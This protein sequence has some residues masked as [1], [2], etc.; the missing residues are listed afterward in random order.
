MTHILSFSRLV[1]LA[2]LSSGNRYLCLR[3]HECCDPFPWLPQ[4]ARLPPSVNF[5]KFLVDCFACKEFRCLL[6]FV[7]FLHFTFHLHHLFHFIF[8]CLLLWLV[9]VPQTH[10]PPP[11]PKFLNV[12]FFKSFRPN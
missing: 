10:T 6:F 7:L 2:R 9:P 4:M 3:R 1:K 12:N 8:V 11:P 5:P